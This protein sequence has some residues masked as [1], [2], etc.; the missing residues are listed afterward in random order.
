MKSFCSRCG[1]HVF[2]GDPE[3]DEI[4]A[5]R[6]GTVDQDPEVDPS[7]HSWS[8][9]APPWYPIPDDGLPRYPQG[10]PR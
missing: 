8:D 1:G 6:L 3:V 7:W 5:V 10:R 4:V 2:A 9:S